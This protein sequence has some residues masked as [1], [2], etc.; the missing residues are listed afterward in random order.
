MRQWWQNV[1]KDYFT[2]SAK[3][4]TGLLALAVVGVA[5]FVLV[6]LWP[7]KN[8]PAD[9]RAFQR[10]LA[11]L[12][13]TID[14]SRRTAQTPKNFSYTKYSYASNYKADKH[15]PGKLFTF[16]P[17]TLDAAGWKQLGIKDKTVETIGKLVS[18]GFRFRQPADIQKI[19]GL[20]ASDVSRL[21]PFVKI[22][23]TPG[24]VSNPLPVVTERPF[25]KQVVD[26]NT[27]DTAGL[28]ALPGIGSKLA[29]RIVTFREKLGG[30]IS[31][32]QIAETYGLS[33]STFQVIKPRLQCAHTGVKTININTAE[34]STLKTHPY[35]KWNLAN[36][37]C[38]YRQQHGNFNSI[39]DLK[40]ID[41][42]T[43]EVFKKLS[44]YLS[45]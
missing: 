28:I 7:V 27:A 42:V 43:D 9:P 10:E 36:A 25:V 17:N 35:I 21:M 20:Q 16:D 29:L 30:F 34:A 5:I 15:L 1:M 44:P 19:Y 41:L 3:E 32:D 33:D 40:K 24:K 6:R 23:E 14:S 18:K 38:N 12:T 2:F 11:Q 13:I 45:L 4:R 26:I 22:A 31:V 37:L 8:Q 39:D